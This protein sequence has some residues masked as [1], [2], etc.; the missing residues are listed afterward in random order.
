MAKTRTPA[1]TAKPLNIR[2]LL[3]A[4]EYQS[5]GSRSRGPAR[6]KVPVNPM[7]GES[8]MEGEQT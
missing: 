4:S 1:T 3:F 5:R 6:K 8:P 7:E 2:Q